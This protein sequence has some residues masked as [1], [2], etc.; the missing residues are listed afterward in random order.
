MI[1]R[2]VNVWRIGV[3]QVVKYLVLNFVIKKENVLTTI[4]VIQVAH[5][6]PVMLVIVALKNVQVNVPNTA[7]VLLLK[8]TTVPHFVNVNLVTLVNCVK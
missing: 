6:S 1:C 4:K 7:R 2:S 8:M 5:V 3:V